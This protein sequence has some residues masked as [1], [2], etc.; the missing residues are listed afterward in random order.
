MIATL[1]IASAAPGTIHS[2]TRL[3]K[4]YPLPDGPWSTE[5]TK[6]QWVDAATQLPCLIVR[7]QV[8]A[9]CGYVGVPPGHPLHRR[10]YDDNDFDVHGGLSF[11]AGCAHSVDEGVGICH[12]PEPGTSDDVWWFG[13]DTAHLGDLVPCL[14]RY[15]VHGHLAETYRDLAYVSAEVTRLAA[16]LKEFGAQ[17]STAKVAQA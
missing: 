6:V 15:D 10:H 8:G 9:L 16:Q 1:E 2:W 13:F 3:D 5:P 4:G 11:S 14:L 17:E 7:N 12:I